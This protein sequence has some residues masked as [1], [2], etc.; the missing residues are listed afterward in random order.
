MFHYSQFFIIRNDLGPN[1]NGL[2]AI[3]GV[4]LLLPLWRSFITLNSEHDLLCRCHRTGL[5]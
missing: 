4:G 5:S 2:V 1:Y 3:S